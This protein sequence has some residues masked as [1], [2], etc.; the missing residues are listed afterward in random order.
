MQAEKRRKH[1]EE[2]I[3]TGLKRPD[4]GEC[5]NGADAESSKAGNFASSKRKQEESDGS[6]ISESSSE[7]SDGLEEI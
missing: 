3:R 1:E 4:E 5:A 6:E 2:M 7:A